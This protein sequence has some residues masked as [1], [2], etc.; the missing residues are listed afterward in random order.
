[1]IIVLVYNSGSVIEVIITKNMVL[2][3]I[4]ICLFMFSMGLFI[5]IASNTCGADGFGLEQ[6]TSINRLFSSTQ[7]AHAENSCVISALQTAKAKSAPAMCKLLHAW[8]PAVQACP[9]GSGKKEGLL[10]LQ[11]MERQLNCSSYHTHQY[12][13]EEHVYNSQSG[14]PSLQCVLATAKKYRPPLEI[15]YCN[16]LSDSKVRIEQCPHDQEQQ[17]F[18]QAIAQEQA[19][20]HCS[21]QA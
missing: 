4:D 15:V 3:I 13:S 10:R 5:L 14:D 11:N 9:D 21:T 16:Y 18:L 7:S 2:P 6:F 8:V 20:S 17:D 19:E 1:M 12:K